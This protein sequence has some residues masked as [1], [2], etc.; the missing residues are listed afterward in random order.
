VIFNLVPDGCSAVRNPGM[1]S[2]CLSGYPLCGLRISPSEPTGDQR[3]RQCLPAGKSSGGWRGERHNPIFDNGNTDL[4]AL[5]ADGVN[6]AFGCRAGGIE[7]D[8]ASKESSHWRQ[9]AAT[10]SQDSASS[11]EAH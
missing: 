9:A 7:I 3:E 4:V 1:E 2:P 5:A 8:K 10:D 11:A 6:G